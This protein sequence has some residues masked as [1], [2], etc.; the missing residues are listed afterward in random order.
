LQ[1]WDREALA[2]H[3]G[4]E[5]L[6]LLVDFGVGV[7][8][9]V[10]LD[11]QVGQPVLE[12]VAVA[13]HHPVAFRSAPLDGLHGLVFRP[14]AQRQL[15][16]V[17]VLLEHFGDVFNGVHRVSPFTQNE[18]RG[19]SFVGFLQDLSQLDGRRVSLIESDLLL[20]LLGHHKNDFL[21]SDAFDEERALERVQ[22]GL[23]LRQLAFVDVVAVNLL[24][25]VVLLGV[26]VVDQAH[27]R[28]RQVFQH[29]E[30]HPHFVLQPLLVWI[31]R[32]LVEPRFASRQQKH[33]F[34]L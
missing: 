8:E 16:N 24:F 27:E 5:Q 26:Q 9:P 2:R 11:Q 20:D 14:T 13:Q 19:G 22:L 4:E 29:A 33:V 17:F 23:S 3:G 12:Q 18:Y 31:G 21:G 15:L 30:V 6:V 10:A 7:L 1:D 28:L 25:E 34:V 32:L